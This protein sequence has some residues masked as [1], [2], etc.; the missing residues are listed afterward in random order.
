[1][2]VNRA[3]VARYLNGRPAV[4]TRLFFSSHLNPAESW[5]IGGVIGDMRESS[6]VQEAEPTVYQSS[7]HAG[8]H[9]TRFWLM[10][11]ARH[12]TGAAVTA[13][14]EVVRAADPSIAPDFRTLDDHLTR[15]SA[16]PRFFAVILV[17]FTA[18]TLLLSGAGIATTLD[19]YVAH[20]TA[21]IGIRV[22]LGAS[23]TSLTVLIMRRITL[24][25]GAAAVA[26]LWVGA[27]LLRFT[28]SLVVP[29]GGTHMPWVTYAVPVATVILIGLAASI[30]PL[31][32]ALSRE[33]LDALRRV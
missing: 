8:R 23:P 5:T 7:L 4:G 16:R 15:Y 33:P 18:F 9:P 28:G 21:E 27:S 30:A 2:F 14:Q 26:G 13:V 3:F 22:A 32:R 29:D 1:V 11:R 10:A 24:L 17:C 6:L 20:R 31:R 19:S 25:L 12:S